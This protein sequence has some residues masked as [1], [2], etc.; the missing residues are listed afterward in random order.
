MGITLV[1]AFSSNRSNQPLAEGICMRCPDRRFDGGNPEVLDRL[2]ELRR[3]GGMSIVNQETICMVTRN[4]FAKLL[5][6][7]LRRGMLGHIE[8]ND[9]TRADLD[10]HQYVED[11]KAGGDGDHEI[12]G[13]DRLCMIVDERVPGFAMLAL[14]QWAGSGSAG[15]LALCE[16]KP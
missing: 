10:Q 2:V 9:A 15:R 1:Q 12:A 6:G 5:Q 11:T 4:G 13:H 16:E 3:K 7:P 14:G 8:V